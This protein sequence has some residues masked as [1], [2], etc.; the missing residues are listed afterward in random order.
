[1]D[2]SALNT[3]GGASATTAASTVKETEDRFLKLLVTQMRNQD[4]MNP[5]DNAQVTTQLAQL[6]TVSGV[7]KLNETMTSLAAQFQSGQMLQASTL[8]GKDVL[9]AGAPLRHD[10]DGA[11]GV[12]SLAGA[13]ERVSVQ[14]QNAAGETLRTLE[15]GAQP[16]GLVNFDWD[17]KSDAGKTV[18]AGAY[19]FV[20][21]AT[22]GGQA[23][24]ADALASGRV[25]SVAVSGAQVTLELDGLGAVALD[26]V[27]RI[28]TQ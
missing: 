20:A 13:A 17:G 23:V 2:V 26:A 14:V 15:L 3:I 10:G 16:A 19:H 12:V 6:S 27:K 9:A 1:M 25:A 28:A 11:R 24:S 22:A 5:L 8:I 18:A 4:P 7:D 21:E